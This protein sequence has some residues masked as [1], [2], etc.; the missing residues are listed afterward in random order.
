MI[1]AGFGGGEDARDFVKPEPSEEHL[2]RIGVV[3]VLVRQR[4]RRGRACATAI[5]AVRF[6][7]EFDGGF[8]RFAARSERSLALLALELEQ[9]PLPTHSDFAKPTLHAEPTQ[10]GPRFVLEPSH[11]NVR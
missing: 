4:G 7:E 5:A 10:L 2:H 6:A 3:H 11:A 9:H 8:G 1:S